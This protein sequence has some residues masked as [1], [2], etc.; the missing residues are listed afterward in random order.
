MPYRFPLA[1]LLRYREMREDQQLQALEQAM[2]EAASA[3]ADLARLADQ[4]RRCEEMRNRAL[5]SAVAGVELH[6]AFHQE[7][8]IRHQMDET[9]Q[10]ISLLNEKVKTVRE[11]YLL[12]L[13]QKNVVASLRDQ[14]AELYSREEARKEQIAADEMFLQRKRD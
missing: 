9:R 4:L 11:S 13:Q 1:T 10:R 14:Q 3:G 12:A 6:H 5:G 7:A 2:S 8:S